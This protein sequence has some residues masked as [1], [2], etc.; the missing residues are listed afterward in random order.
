MHQLS[1]LRL[2]VRQRR[3][4]YMY[5]FTFLVGLLIAR[6]T[7]NSSQEGKQKNQA[8]SIQEGISETRKL[9]F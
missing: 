3:S 7:L 6:F 4:I 1:K 8:A 5:M 9:F 2:S